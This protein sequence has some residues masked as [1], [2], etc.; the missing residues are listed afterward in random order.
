MN[1]S[2][3]I[4]ALSREADKSAPFRHQGIIYYPGLTTRKMSEI[5]NLRYKYYILDFGV[6]TEHTLPEFKRCDHRV[7]ITNVSM[8]KSAKLERFAKQ[9]HKNNIPW[10][11]LK[12]VGRDGTKSD[13]ARLHADFGIQVEPMPVLK[14]PFR[15]TSGCF[16]FFEEIMKGD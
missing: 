14:D 1:A 10:N 15:I 4:C 2:H 9:L 13:Y 12:T 11:T 6:L 5:M 8:W 16:H 7:V 3:E